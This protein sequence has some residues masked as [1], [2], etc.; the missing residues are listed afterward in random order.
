MHWA[1][2]GLARE[3]RKDVVACMASKSWA[4]N[5]R[6]TGSCYFQTPSV[7]SLIVKKLDPGIADESLL[8]ASRW[9]VFWIDSDDL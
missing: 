2:Y 4:K 8:I 7:F 3:Q 6:F 5:Y 9:H 1:I